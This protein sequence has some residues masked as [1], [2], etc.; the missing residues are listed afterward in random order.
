M[1]KSVHVRNGINVFDFISLCVFD[2]PVDTSVNEQ[3]RNQSG[4]DGQFSATLLSDIKKA[5]G[6]EKT[7][8]LFVALQT[9]K[10]T[11]DYE[12]MVSTVVGLLTE[13]DEDIHLLKSESVHQTTRRGNVSSCRKLLG[14]A[15]LNVAAVLCTVV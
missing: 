5:V 9:Y 3:A 13:R 11:N 4:K 7:K 12:Q 8:Q 1:L 6:A 10:K 14:V 15:V 2:S